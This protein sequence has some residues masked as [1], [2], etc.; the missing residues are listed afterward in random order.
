MAK[1][2]AAMKIQGW[3][4][5]LAIGHSESYCPDLEDRDLLFYIQAIKPN[6]GNMYEVHKTL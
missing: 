5:Q 2:A 6:I 4:L 3:L 1:A